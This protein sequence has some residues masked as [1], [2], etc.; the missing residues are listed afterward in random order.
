MFTLEEFSTL[1]QE[2]VQCAIAENIDR[3]PTDIALDRRVPA[4][5][6]VA[7]QVKRL[8]RARSKLPSYYAVRAI[9]PPRAYEQSSSEECAARKRLCGE[10]VLDLTCGLGVDTMALARRFRRVVALERDEVL[11]AVTRH[12]LQ[13]LGIEN[14]TIIN[15][16][17]EEFLSTCEQHFDWC[18][19]DPDRRGEA[20]EKLVRLE[21]C[22]PNMVALRSDIERIADRICIK[23]SPL[24][25]TAEAQHLF[26]DCS[27]ESVSLAGECKEVNIYIDGTTPTLAAEAIGLGRVEVPW[28]EVGNYAPGEPPTD[29]EAYRYLILPDVALQHSRLT[30]YALAGRAD[31]WSAT[32]I[33]LSTEA[34]QGVP[35]RIFEIGSILDLGNKQTK[36][37]LRGAKVEI[38]RR[39]MP[40]SNGELCRRF[41]MREGGEQR[42]CFTKI[43][44]RS[45]AIEMKKM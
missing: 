22:S 27:V 34:P 15:C 35:G 31:V 29:L 5:A 8:Q 37:R 20:G 28:A 10:S 42:W 43:G 17:A 11:A 24:F 44:T 19:A 12:N 30:A 2:Q 1:C 40:L 39:D 38:Y 16:S 41:G 25:D 13:R 32:G 45:V 33:A 3:T 21:D 23:C 9:L 6:A 18:F 14:V 4:A 7:T 26:G 36:R